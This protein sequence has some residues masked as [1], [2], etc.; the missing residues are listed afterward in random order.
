[1]QITK[2]LQLLC[3]LLLVSL[4]V[5]VLACEDKKTQPLLTSPFYDQAGA[6]LWKH[7]VN[8]LADVDSMARLFPGIEIDITY[9]DSTARFICSHGEPCSG[10]SM[11]TLLSSIGTE[12]LP[13][14]WLDFK[15]SDDSLVVAKSIV[16]LK[17]KLTKLNLVERT[18]VETRNTRCLDSLTKYG[19]FSSYWVPHDYDKNPTYTNEELTS[20]IR[21]TIEQHRP[22]VLSANYTMF[23]FLKAQFPNEFLHLWTN[24]LITDEH[25]TIINEMR[26]YPN[27]KVVLVDYPTLF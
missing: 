21:A 24:G 9:M 22:T 5:S 8:C 19:L 26:D 25:K 7:R 18:I 4:L 10:E 12:R 14:V 20:M 15:N 6:K 2:P 11:E 13:Y 27:T 23:N 1:M 17:E 3:N 16:I